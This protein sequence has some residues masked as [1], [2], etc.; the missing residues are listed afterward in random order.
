MNPIAFPLATAVSAIQPA[1]LSDI[2]QFGGFC[3][4]D[5]DCVAGMTERC[6]LF[7]TYI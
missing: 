4:V 7:I 5:S 6:S 3:R 2:C 1:V